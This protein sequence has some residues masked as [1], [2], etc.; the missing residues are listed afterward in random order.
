V[1]QC[2]QCGTS[3]DYNHVVCVA[4]WR[5]VPA[6]IRRAVSATRR[7]RLAGN[8]TDRDYTRHEAAVDAMRAWFASHTE[9]V[10]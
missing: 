3:L 2:M 8:A 5:S 4:C 10:P 9:R 1:N 6:D 7:R